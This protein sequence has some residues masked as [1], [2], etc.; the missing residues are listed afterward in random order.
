MMATA[1]DDGSLDIVRIV[2]KRLG[3]A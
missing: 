3:Q 1:S 2:P